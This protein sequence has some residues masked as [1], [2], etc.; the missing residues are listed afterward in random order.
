MFPDLREKKTAVY[1]RID[2]YTALSLKHR[3]SQAYEYPLIQ[4]CD[5]S[6]IPAVPGIHQNVQEIRW[7]IYGIRV[8]LAYN[9]QC[10]P[11]EVQNS[12]YL[13]FRHI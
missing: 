6:G 8:D 7:N 11:F 1:P 10:T 5:N 2:I 4:N 3:E 9:R 12:L 13:N